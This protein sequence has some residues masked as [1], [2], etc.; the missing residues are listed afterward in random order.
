MKHSWVIGWIAVRE[1]IY[2]RVF[3]L[4]F[5]FALLSIGVSLLL[6]QL[7][8][9]GQSKLTLDFLLGAIQFSMTLFSIFM[10]ISLFHRELAQGSISLVLSK[11]INRYSFIFGKYLGQIT[12]ELFV[13]AAMIG[14]VF[15]ATSRFE[16]GV[17]HLAIAQ[18]VLLIFFE[19]LV[20]TAVTYFFA[21]N[22][23]VITAAIATLFLVGLGH[24]GEVKRIQ[25]G[26]VEHVTKTL[27]RPLIPNLEI[28]NMKS[29]ASY[30]QCISSQEIGWAFLYALTCTGMFLCLAAVTFNRKDVLT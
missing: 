30:G 8:Y 17:S 27:L 15:L 6:G 2:E 9:A 18:T 13:L 4:L 19:I 10:G 20:I 3:Y 7:T 23:G 5:S 26:S 14:V 25:T 11:P 28:F 16:E 12:V 21:V 1:L 22:A 29:L 24:L